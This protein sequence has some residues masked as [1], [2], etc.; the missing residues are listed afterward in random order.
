MT[1]ID[2]PC[3]P[4]SP[5]DQARE[6]CKYAHFARATHYKMS[7]RRARVQQWLGGTTIAIS[8]VVSTG[9]L[10]SVSA[11]DPSF[12]LKLAAGIVA[13]F[14]TVFTGFQ[15]FYKFGEIGEKHRLAA[16]NY[17]ALRSDLQRFLIRYKDDIP[18]E[19]SEALVDL[20]KLS[21]RLA[22]LDRAG[23]GYP[24]RTY[25][26]VAKREANGETKRRN[27]LSGRTRRERSS[28]EHR[29]GEPSR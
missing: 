20:H 25:D 3:S 17:G 2:L 27:P 12:G 9:I 14:A 23:P 10:A 22:E 29:S 24:G 26:R 15:T 28:A 5:L 6:Y 8:A 4:A 16:A 19:R 18:A 1:A 11:K 7:D 21:E 13:L